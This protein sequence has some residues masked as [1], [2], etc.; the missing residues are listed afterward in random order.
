MKKSALAAL[1]APLTLSAFLC[2]AGPIGMDGRAL[3]EPPEPAVPTRL[4]YLGVHGSRL[5]SIF[6]DA[7]RPA[8]EGMVHLNCRQLNRY[9]TYGA[10]SRSM[11]PADDTHTTS[12]IDAQQAQFMRGIKALG[13]RLI[14]I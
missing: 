6:H 8:G 2:S 12:I 11:V 3:G 14:E 1:A 5:A 9:H 13:C 7:D 4:T 10:L